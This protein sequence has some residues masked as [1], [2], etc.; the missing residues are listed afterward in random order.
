MLALG[1]LSLAGAGLYLRMA[2]APDHVRRHALI[3]D[4]A[5]AMGAR[6]AGATRLEDA[7][8]QALATLGEAPSGDAFSV[9]G[10]ALEA[11]LL[12]AQ[13][14]NR[15]S[16]RKTIAALRPLAVPARR[17][18]LTAALM[19]AR[20][21]DTIDLYSDRGPPVS[22]IRAAGVADRLRVH[23]VGSPADNLAIVSLDPGVVRF[24]PGR[25]VLRNF[26]P[27]SRLCELA[28]D[29]D[30]E[31]V[32][33]TTVMLEPRGQ[34]VVAFGP[35][36]RGGLVSARI[37][38]DD[39]L[40]ADNQ[41]WAYAQSDAPDKVLL[42][43]PDAAVRDD[44]ARVL[45]AVNQSF[46]IT[47]LDA[48]SFR[49]EQQPGDFSLVVMHDS[50]DSRLD[51]VSRLR[52]IVYPPAPSRPSSSPASSV[53]NAMELPITGAL[54]LVELRNRAGA[55]DLPRSP[56]LGPARVLALPSWMEVLG[57][58]DGNSGSIPLAAYGRD[59]QGAVGV[60]AFDVRDHLLLDPDRIDALILAV[61]LL[62]HLLAPE[63]LQIVSTGSYATVPAAGSARVV[64]P[65]GN[66]QT[67]VASS[68]GRIRFRALQAGRYRIESSGRQAQVYAN[69]FD[70]AES[71]LAGS[72]SVSAEAGSVGVTARAVAPGP[73]E[74]FPLDPALITLALLAFLIESAIILRSAAGWGWRH[75]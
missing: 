24:S 15:E 7:R 54:P 36:V 74:V 6:E 1:A 20:D 2:A 29:C 39:A 58:G 57:S 63:D 70:A 10:Y 4:L 45:L 14:A 30:G 32:S 38:N 51:A 9:I 48:K 12:H 41:R 42:V 53:S 44:L 22:E 73:A 67:L 3:F 16:I 21:S 26:S 27:H 25:C 75:V 18:A 59:R 28:I 31:R 66:S 71:D 11:R 37:P 19:R 62:R 49:A 46:I 72:S 55:G 60:I 5:A 40:A 13:S 34:A 47:A 61:E 56:R 8:R 17:C 68:D 43:S 65:D 33:R 50:Y 35:L 23:R 69:Y 52:L 64:A